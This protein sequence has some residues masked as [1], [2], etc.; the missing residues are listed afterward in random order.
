MS[1]PPNILLIEDN[2]DDLFLTHRILK[3]AGLTALFHVGDG[4][5]AVDYLA[6]RGEFA[7]RATHP[8]P[9]IMLVDIGLPDGSGWDLVADARELRPELRIGVVTGWEPRNE[10]DPACN[11]NIIANE[12]K[13]AE[14]EAAISNSFA[15]GG[16]NAVVAFRRWDK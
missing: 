15:F 3:K 9:D 7:D 2:E 4:H 13:A 6:G 12:A 10:Q 16:L 14:P 1:A 5:A 11:L 8:L